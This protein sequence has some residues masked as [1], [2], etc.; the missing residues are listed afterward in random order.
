MWGVR[1]RFISQLRA[2]CEIRHPAEQLL[3]TKR[4]G[5]P[6]DGA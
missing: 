5:A 2:R 6:P 3:G 1:Q 4:A